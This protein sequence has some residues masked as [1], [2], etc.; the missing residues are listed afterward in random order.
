MYLSA[1]GSLVGESGQSALGLEPLIQTLTYFS[2]GRDSGLIPE[3]SI[4]K[5]SYEETWEFFSEGEASS[6]QTNY[7]QYDRG[8]DLIIDSEYTAIPGIEIPLVAF[9]DGWAWAISTSDPTQQ[10]L[11]SELLNWMVAGPNVGDWALEASKL[12]GRR[13][14]FE[15]WPDND[16]YLVFIQRELDRADRYPIEATDE[17]MSALNNAIFDVLTASKSPQ[18]AAEDAIAALQS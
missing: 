8:R 18:Q 17:I 5:T 15:Q 1:G 6:V 12:P 3:E 2:Q 13:S 7:Q 11:A 14:G 16:P 9:V 4:D 10:Q